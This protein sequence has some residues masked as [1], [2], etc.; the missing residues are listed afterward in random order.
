VF[1]P[2]GGMFDVLAS[3]DKQDIGNALTQKFNDD[4]VKGRYFREYC[5][6]F[7]NALKY[8]LAGFYVEW[9]EETGLGYKAD[10]GGTGEPTSMRL[11]AGNCVESLPMYNSFWDPHCNPCDVHRDG[12]FAGW[13]EISSPFQFKRE[14]EKGRYFNTREVLG[15]TASAPSG[16]QWFQAVPEVRIDN[17]GLSSSGIS[18]GGEVNWTRLFTTAYS[19]IKGYDSTSGIE[20]V[21]LFI[22]LIHTEFGLVPETEET[23]NK[24]EIWKITI[25]NGQKI[26][27][28]SMQNNMHDYLPLFFTMPI[29]DDLGLQVK[30]VAENLAPFQD[31]ISFMLNSFVNSTRKNIW[32]LTVYDPSIVDLSKIGD[33][34]SARV[35]MTPN[36]MGKDPKASIFHFNKTL[37]TDKLLSQI[38][39]TLQFME[40]LFP[41]RML[42]QVADIDRAV[43]D[44]VAATV[45]ASQRES[46]KL[47]KTMDD[48]TFS[49][50]RFVMYSNNIQ[51]GDKLQVMGED[52]KW[53]DFQMA[54]LRGS[55]LEF[56]M[57]E[58]LKTIDKLSRQLAAKEIMNAVLSS[59]AASEFNIPDMVDYFSS[60]QGLEF[61]LTQF[62]KTDAQ[63]DADAKRVAMAKAQ[64]QQPTGAA[65]APPA[66]Q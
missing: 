38:Q 18:P 7:L 10:A 23:R 17:N 41:T 29:E 27:S 64:S 43:K 51:Y 33:D 54:D 11:H 46:W 24:L 40:W 5:K 13:A 52:G 12:E 22:R 26:V 21:H 49:P 15:G 16:D 53:K 47:A 44:Q 8:N 4:S 36:G 39:E 37:E 14:I 59:G 65:V 61:D 25:A 60:Q 1:S 58:G 56:R 2:E 31:L 32:D 63:K 62:R 35:P 66:A 20:L 57:G 48:Q 50:L 6:F 30:S 9:R 45:A 28:A 3:K 42:Q 34:V 55:K 19:S